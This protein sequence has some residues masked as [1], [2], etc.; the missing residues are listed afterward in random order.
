MP[1]AQGAASARAVVS[2]SGARLPAW[3]V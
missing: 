3:A 1:V 2:A